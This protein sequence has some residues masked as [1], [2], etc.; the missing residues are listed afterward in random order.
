MD[1][2]AALADGWLTVSV[3]NTGAWV[4]PDSSRSPGSGI[5]TLRKRLGLLI[6]DEALRSAIEDPTPHHDLGELWFERTG[7][8]MVFAVWAAR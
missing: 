2:A 6:G 3:V 7:L 4:R 1:V 8:P 5:Q